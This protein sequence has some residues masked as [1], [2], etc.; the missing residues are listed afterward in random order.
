METLTLLLLNNL[1]A[2]S[3]VKKQRG[4]L[5][6]NRIILI[7]LLI[8]LSGCSD[9]PWC[10]Q[11]VNQK[12]RRERFD[13]CLKNIPKGPQTTKYNDWAEVVSQCDNIAYYQSM[14]KPKGCE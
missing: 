10:A 6:M 14:E 8:V 2:E 12:I 9:S 7:A 13:S 5:E 4:V 3:L 1:T 11:G